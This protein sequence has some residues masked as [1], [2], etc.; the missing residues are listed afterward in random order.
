MDLACELRQFPESPPWVTSGSYF[1]LGDQLGAKSFRGCPMSQADCFR[2]GVNS[3]RPALTS[4]RL[5]QVDDK[6]ISMPSGSTL[7]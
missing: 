3:V 7:Q 1:P 4:L 5:T 2:D 6:G